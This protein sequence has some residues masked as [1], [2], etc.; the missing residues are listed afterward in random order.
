MLISI[1]RSVEEVRPEIP[2]DLVRLEHHF[3]QPVRTHNIAKQN[4]RFSKIN[5]CSVEDGYVVE[6]C[7][8]EG[9]EMLLADLLILPLTHVFFRYYGIERTSTHLKLVY[10]WYNLILSNERVR[11]SLSVLNF[12][13]NSTEITNFVVPEVKKES[14]YKC[15]PRRYKTKEKM[16]T[17]QDDVDHVI[18]VINAMNVLQEYE[19]FRC[20]EPSFDWKMVPFHAHPEGGNLPV[21]RLERKVQQI[22]NIVRPVL[23]VSKLSHNCFFLCFPF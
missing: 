13:T 16:F 8:V 20:G 3:G 23:S 9:P 19:Y 4:L 22:E 2:Q 17:K 21:K 6:H 10:K 7:Y 14:L 5:G 18:S 11:S 1:Q 15:D 12:H